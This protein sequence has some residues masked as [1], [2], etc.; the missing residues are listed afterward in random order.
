M[1]HPTAIV[2]SKAQIDSDVSIGAYTVIGDNVSIGK[3]SIIGP[4]VVVDP[5]V[6]IGEECQI[7][8]F[9]SIGAIPQSLRYEGEKSSVTIED[10][11]IIREF[12][13]INR[14][15]K[16]G[17]GSTR[18]GANCLIMASAHI[19][20][21]CH[22]GHHVVMANCATLAGHITIGNHANIGGLVG[23][24]QFVRIGNFAIVGGKSAVV[25]DVPPFMMAAGDRARLHGL[26]MVGL[27]RNGFSP[28]SLLR[29]KKAYRIIFRFGL[30]LNEALARV[31][32]QLPSSPEIE[33]LLTFINSS[34]RGITR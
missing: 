16:D 22:L 25:K 27:K 6:T 1:I 20:H 31:S 29:L 3:G 4:H 5:Q 14:G 13:T 12:V 28:E 19:A 23:I 10:K 33:E 8:Q 17:G 7:F 15:T 24:H 34:K 21:D 30:T 32:A 9:A 2:S 26:N 18:I 11:C